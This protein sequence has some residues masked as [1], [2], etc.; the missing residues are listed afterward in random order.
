MWSDSD[1]SDDED[2]EITQLRQRK[3]RAFSQRIY[4]TEILWPNRNVNR[5][6][7]GIMGTTNSVYLVKIDPD[8][9]ICCSCPDCNISRNF[10]KHCLFVVLRVLSVPFEHVTRNIP[11]YQGNNG[12]FSVSQIV[13]T[14]MLSFLLDHERRAS[15]GELRVQNEEERN[16]FSQ[17]TIDL[18]NNNEETVTVGKK[19]PEKKRPLEK[20][21][22]ERKAI[23]G[24][25]SICFEEMSDGKE[26]IVFCRFSCGQNLHQDCMLKW[27]NKKR[28][29]DIT[30]PYC[31]APWF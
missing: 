19:K 27:S 20:P 11:R 13:Y 9:G 4:L 3:E 15:I 8:E 23:E 1:S 29:S 16:R 28:D 14:N 18:F 2:Q 12:R 10:C 5:A 17:E 25:C 7:F 24:E 26:E 6:T 31:R 30:C 22:V 21:E